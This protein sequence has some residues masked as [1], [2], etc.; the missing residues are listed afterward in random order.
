MLNYLKIYNEGGSEVDNRL[1]SMFTHLL[2]SILSHEGDRSEMESIILFLHE[3]KA[4]TIFV[5]GI[6]GLTNKNCSTAEEPMLTNF[7]LCCAAMGQY[8]M[9]EKEEF[10][11]QNGVRVIIRLIRKVIHHPSNERHLDPVSVKIIIMNLIVQFIYLFNFLQTA[12]CHCRMC[13]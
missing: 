10:M 5:E 13:S 3:N 11:Y 7:L 1:A 4:M 12:Y 9:S 8:E 6:H 2:R